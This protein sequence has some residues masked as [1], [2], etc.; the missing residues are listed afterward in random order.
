MTPRQTPL[1]ATPALDDFVAYAPARTCIYLPCKT[2]WPNASI[3][4]RLP[5]QPLLDK[6][7][8]PVKNT[9]GK[10]TTIPASTWLEQHR[11]VETQTWL[12]GEP[13]FIRD[14]LAVEGG[15]VGKTG[16]T[17]L[18]TYRPPVVTPG[19]AK[20]A[21]RWI[22]HW[23]ALY[24]DDANH[25]TAWLAARVQHP[26]IKINH[27]LVLGGAPMIGKDTLLEPVKTA[28]GEWNYRDIGLAGLISRDNEYFRGVIVHV[29]EARD[30]GEQGRIDRYGLYDHLKSTLA[31]PPNTIRVN[32]KYIREYW[33]WN[34]F[35]MVITTNHRDALYLPADD[36]RHYIAWSERL[37]TDF[38]PRFW[39][40]F[41]AWY[42]DGG[43]AHVTAYL[44]EYDLASFDPKA[45]PTKTSAFWSMVDA[46]RS[47][48]YAELADAVDALGRPEALT[49]RQ[50]AAKSPSLEWLLDRKRRAQIKHRFEDCG[51]LAVR[52]HDR[53]D[54]LWMVGKKRQVIY[55][56]A[57][58][59]HALRVEAARNLRE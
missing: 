56:R 50:V 13:E 47:D 19:D 12:P 18:N 14:K 59:T 1:P 26:E 6:N 7:G 41:W 24:P 35:G 57:N 10:I 52:N 23:K 36:R 11:S 55:A 30:M 8:N 49:L 44:R 15:W 43:I 17:T 27:A 40:D 42:R 39:N 38:E 22:E 28:V 9:K 20:Q 54:G 25:I 51:Y 5:R 37:G 2:H 31:T 33:V 53:D 4:T 48:E 21:G 34:R 16:T 58:L 32:E 3:D 46:D 29:S 45:P